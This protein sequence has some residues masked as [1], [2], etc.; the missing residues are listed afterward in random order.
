[1]GFDS[2]WFFIGRSLSPLKLFGV[3][4]EV[5]AGAHVSVDTSR[6]QVDNGN[7]PVVSFAHNTG[8]IVHR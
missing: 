2:Y 8:L 5:A 1:M 6:R 7:L 3:Q 4:I